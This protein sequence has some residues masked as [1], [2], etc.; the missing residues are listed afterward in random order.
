MLLELRSAISHFLTD[1]AEAEH[2]PV[3]RCVYKM[4]KKEGREKGVTGAESRD[5]Q[6]EAESAE[7]RRKELGLWKDRTIKKGKRF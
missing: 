2:F 4:S 5:V 6:L 7:G 3:D 1:V